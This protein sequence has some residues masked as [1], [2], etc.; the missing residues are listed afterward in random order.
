MPKWTCNSRGVQTP[1]KLAK[2]SQIK[3]KNMLNSMTYKKEAWVH[4]TLRENR[5]KTLCSKLITGPFPH[6][7][8]GLWKWSKS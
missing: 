5:E 8:N 4:A 1:K 3:A 7:S 2:V 6:I